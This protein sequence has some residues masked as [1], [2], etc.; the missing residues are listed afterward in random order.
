MRILKII[1]KFVFCKKYRHRHKPPKTGCDIQ[2]AYSQEIDNKAARDAG[3]D[4]LISKP[5]NKD[6]FY[7]TMARY[8]KNV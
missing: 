3:C 7:E 8:C 1:D 6:A 4:Y 2:T 5:I